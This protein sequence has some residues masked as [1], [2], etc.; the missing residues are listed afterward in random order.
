LLLVTLCLPN[1]F[2]PMSKTVVACAENQAA[3][4]HLSLVAARCLGGR[5]EQ[6]RFSVLKAMKSLKLYPLPIES[7][8][9]ALALEG[10]GPALAKELMKA[11]EASKKKS[12]KPPQSNVIETT[13]E[14]VA[15]T[16]EEEQ[17][18]LLADE[19][20]S[21]LSQYSYEVEMSVPHDWGEE[22]SAHKIDILSLGSTR[23]CQKSSAL[24]T[25]RRIEETSPESFPI[26][27]R[28]R[29]NSSSSING[30]NLT[31]EP[32]FR[33]ILLEIPD[34][35]QIVITASENS[36]PS[37]STHRTA[38]M[39]PAEAVN[40]CNNSYYHSGLEYQPRNSEQN[41]L[42]LHR[43]DDTKLDRKKLKKSMKSTKNE[44]FQNISAMKENISNN[45]HFLDL[46]QSDPTDTEH[47]EKACRKKT[48]IPD[49]KSHF[50]QSSTQL[51]HDENSA[52]H[53]SCG[54]NSDSNS[55]VA[56][57][58]SQSVQ[59]PCDS[60]RNESST[61]SLSQLNILD[62]SSRQFA[63]NFDE[64]SRDNGEYPKVS[65]TFSQSSF[66]DSC[67]E[68]GGSE[69]SYTASYSKS[70]YTGT[71]TSYAGSNSKSSST[72][73]F[74]A[75]SAFCPSSSAGT[76]ERS[77][78]SPAL[79]RQLSSSSTLSSAPLN[80]SSSAAATTAVD[81]DIDRSVRKG[82]ASS[83]SS[84]RSKAQTLDPLI[85]GIASDKA[86][87]KGNAPRAKQVNSSRAANINLKDRDETD[88]DC[89]V[90]DSS[91]EDGVD[92]CDPHSDPTVDPFLGPL[93]GPVS[94]WEP[95]LIVDSRE[96]DYALVQVGLKT[97][98]MLVF[99]SVCVT[100]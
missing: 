51:I 87:R 61:P 56:I 42:K 85:P 52:D 64:H 81:I 38:R 28:N 22:S 6:Y 11:V 100:C 39:I 16:G 82:S 77:S 27:V 54:E 57:F 25:K 14:T 55:D 59:R 91:D 23:I 40:A 79:L 48:A 60:S 66:S 62:L 86:P 70:S 71:A 26:C 83:S 65:L 90:I 50:L 37:E 21:R 19:S 41:H 20:S 67:E 7:I 8:E 35:P 78:A 53:I 89:L 74:S 95:V 73:A 12:L 88:T 44:P 15:S 10:V 32:S 24:S 93:L 9:E 76:A 43:S 92:P 4:I 13:A 72:F 29:Q 2:L 84:V 1:N 33:K 63:L 46:T 34:S 94:N 3:F 18:V 98:D 49:S 99:V 96:K 69:Y 31:K 75:S 36:N 45:I 30:Q 58:E 5:R 97:L 80:S 68:T 17:D 47:V